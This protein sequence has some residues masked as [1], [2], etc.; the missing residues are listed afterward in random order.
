MAAL[1]FPGF[2]FFDMVRFGFVTV[3]LR[4]LDSSN[5]LALNFKTDRVR[6]EER[7]GGAITGAWNNGAFPFLQN[8]WY[9]VVVECRGD[10]VRVWVGPACGPLSQALDAS[11][12]SILTTSYFYMG[13]STSGTFR[14][15][16]VQMESLTW[17]EAMDCL[18]T[19]GRQKH[20]VGFDVVEFAPLKGLHHPDLTAAKLVSKILNY[21]L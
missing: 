10:R 17:A 5:L 14:Y 12:S 18:R 6:L 1:T 2:R 16:D 13:G 4:Y 3:Y 9:D 7:V 19:I 8:V 11:V 20:I 21:A 15:D